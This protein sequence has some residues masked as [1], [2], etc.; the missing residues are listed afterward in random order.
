[1]AKET[2]IEPAGLYTSPNQRSSVPAGAM[3][4]ATNV[5]IRRPGMVESRR[6]Y[7]TLTGDWSGT[8]AQTAQALHVWR[9]NATDY[10]F[11]ATETRLLRTDE[12]A[13]AYTDFGA[14]TA[15]TDRHRFA[16]AKKNL[17]LT[18][19]AGVYRLD[20]YNGTPTLSGIAKPLSIAVSSGG[21][22]GGWLTDPGSVAYRAV[23]KY[24]DANGNV[25][26]SAPSSRAVFRNSGLGTVAVAV[27]VYL[28]TGLSSSYSIQVYR[29]AQTPSASDE[30]SDEMGL[31]YERPLTSS[32]ATN[33]S[34]SVTNNDIVPDAMRGASLY[35]NPS[36]EGILQANERPPLANDILWHK[37]TMFY[38]RTTSKHRLTL[39]L[40]SVSGSF[41]LQNND[42]VTL[43]G[44]AYTAKTT[45]A[46]STDFQLYTSS[47]S[48]QV[49]I[50]QTVQNLINVINTESTNTSIY[51]YYLSGPDDP[52]GVFL[53]EER[54]VG[55]S[56][57]SAISSRA[58]CWAPE[59][60]SSGSTVASDNDDRPNRIYFSK[61]GQP[62]A[63]PLLNYVDV[64]NANDKVLR[65]VRSR[66]SVFVF[67]EYDGLYR[68]S[69]EPGALRVQELD[70]TVQLV[71]I[72]SVTALQNQVYALCTQGVVAISESGAT[73]VSQSIEDVFLPAVTSDHRDNVR[74]GAHAVGYDADQLYILWFPVVADDTIP[75]QAYVYCPMTSAWT[76]W[77][78]GAA[79]SAV[80]LRT[81]KLVFSLVSTQTVSIEAKTFADADYADA[82][83][84]ISVACTFVPK[85]A[86]NPA[87][88]KSWSRA[89]FLMQ[90]TTATT[91]TAGFA[92]DISTAEETVAL[93]SSADQAIVTSPIP[94]AKQLGTNLTVSLD[95][96]QASKKFAMAGFVI[97]HT[98]AGE[99]ARR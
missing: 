72:N 42:T 29:S 99:I 87:A 6:G 12:G 9:T 13:G 54:G 89:D 64:G 34:V 18:T 49:N 31:V 55:G 96:S 92:T 71:A 58:T 74:I 59:L 51:A 39:R 67:K 27:T 97:T 93:S 48:P 26:F 2:V 76:K 11:I 30:P 36:Q 88:L 56:A 3:T 82:G 21:A 45:P 20:A 62:E 85:F 90:S 47:S 73:V 94:Q 80:N 66:D 79:A 63:V 24:E 10:I 50:Q 41:G 23:I 28:P 84:A 86:G 8:T 83:A 60:P 33:R 78:F 70:S 53:L 4:E 61:L 81:N 98:D 35:S 15:L 91:L 16:E 38:A 77:G 40:L 69:G 57:F 65:I 14:I 44:V 19:G 43:G 22:T 68:I 17:Y 25:Y 75:R 1:M 52:A 5:V 46:A 32:E 95:C 7:A 37:Q